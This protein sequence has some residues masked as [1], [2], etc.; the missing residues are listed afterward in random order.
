MEIDNDIKLDFNDVLLAPKPSKLTSRKDVDLVRKFT[1]PYGREFSGVP[2]IA[3]NM[4]TGTFAMAREFKRKQMFVA[5][6]KHNNHLWLDE[7]KKDNHIISHAIFTIGASEKEFYE[8]SDFYHEVIGIKDIDFARNIKLL[9]DVANAHTEQTTQFVKLVRSHYKSIVVMV[10]NVANANSTAELILAGAD[11]VKVGIGPGSVCTTRKQTGVGYPQLSACI[12]NS[13]IAD[14]YDGG[15]ILDGGL[16]TP[17]DIAKAFCAGAEFVMMGGMFSGTDESDGEVYTE[18]V[19]SS[20]QV[21]Y[22]GKFIN[23]I[24]TIK[25]KIFYGMSSDLAQ[26]EHFGGKK[27]YATSEGIVERVDY[28]GPVEDVL[29]DI[30]GG[31][32]STGTYINADTIDKFKHNAKFI[33]VTH[34]H[35][36]F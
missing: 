10:G 35:D 36:K 11:Y 9:I 13:D 12:E 19:K 1:P 16:R 21:W 3:A 2:I 23:D 33:R 15:I 6:A 14:V 29:N 27:D 4:A 26:Q 28:I 22:D 31:L 17:G 20:R 34:I 5:I 30:L 18:D 32:R 7:F 25:Y 24:E 8:F